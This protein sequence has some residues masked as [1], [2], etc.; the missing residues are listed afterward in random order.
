MPLSVPHCE[1][2]V[3]A[4]GTNMLVVE[5]IAT[6][7]RRQNPATHWNN[8]TNHKYQAPAPNELVEGYKSRVLFN[9][10]L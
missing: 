4:I 1:M 5:L 7:S 3:I 8:L 9:G 6:L 10:A 2:D